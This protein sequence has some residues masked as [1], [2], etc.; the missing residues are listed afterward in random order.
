LNKP[1]K[2]VDV[3]VAWSKGAEIEKRI[4]GYHPEGYY[5]VK[6]D[7]PDWNDDDAKFRIKPTPK[8]PQYLYVYKCPNGWLATDEIAKS[9]QF[10]FIGKIKLEGDE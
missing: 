9:S 5:W 7:N 6:E 4:I 1:H 2:W 10:K 3:I 8:E